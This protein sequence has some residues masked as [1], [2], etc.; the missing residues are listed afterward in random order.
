MAV[1][2]APLAPVSV[3]LSGAEVCSRWPLSYQTHLHVQ[4]AWS[5]GSAGFSSRQSWGSAGSRWPKLTCVANTRLRHALSATT[6]VLASFL[7]IHAGERACIP[8][9]ATARRP[10]L[11]H[12]PQ[13]V[14]CSGWPWMEAATTCSPLLEKLICWK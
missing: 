3:T 10:T 12:L 6:A 8:G 11:T 13:S 5:W 7:C 4:A 1:R 14:A 9:C 2:T